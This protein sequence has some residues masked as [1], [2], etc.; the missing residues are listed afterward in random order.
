MSFDNNIAMSFDN[1]TCCN[2]AGHPN[3]HYA[4]CQH[5]KTSQ[6]HG[7]QSPTFLNRHERRKQAKEQR[8]K[9]KRNRK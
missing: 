4:D 5:A 1:H 8:V 9:N 6:A 7:H 3:C 2:I